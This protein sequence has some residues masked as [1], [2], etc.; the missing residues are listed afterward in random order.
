VGLLLALALS[1]VAC[2]KRS[3]DCRRLIGKVNASLREID[4]RPA[5]A[6][7]DVPAVTKDRT[8]L[9]R[10]YGRLSDEV[11]ALRLSDPELVSRAKSYAGVARAASDAMKEG[12]Q[13]L[14]KRDPEAV[15]ESRRRFDMVTRREAA[16]VREI[17]GVCLPDAVPSDSA[18]P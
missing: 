4:G 10:R 6:L 1:S 11:L 9:A 14:E 7:D 18:S 3:G 12:V 8:E 17:N 5:V 2:S 16:L 15:E 13:A